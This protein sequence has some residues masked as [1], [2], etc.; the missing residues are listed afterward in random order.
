MTAE[1]R[2]RRKKGR[3]FTFERNVISPFS[4]SL[5]PATPVIRR[6]RSPISS[7]PTSWAISD[8]FRLFAASFLFGVVVIQN[9][10]D[11]GGKVVAFALINQHA[12]IE[13]ISVAL[14]LAK[15]LDH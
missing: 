12:V 4:A 5:M 7:P 11:L 15:V 10:D 1:A 6:L 9:L 8:S 2:V 13:D 3:Y 14:G